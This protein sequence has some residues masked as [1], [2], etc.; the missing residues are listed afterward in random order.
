MSSHLNDFLE[1]YED[2]GCCAPE[3]H[4][5]DHCSLCGGCIE[6]GTCYCEARDEDDDG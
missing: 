3:S 5:Y 1:D 4:E 6:C 2:D